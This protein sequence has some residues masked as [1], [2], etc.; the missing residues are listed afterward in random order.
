MKFTNPI[1]PGFAPDPS[2]VRDWE[3]TGHAICRSSQLDLSR[4]FTKLIPLPDER[5]I[6]V[7]GGLFAATIRYHKGFFYVICTN[8]FADP[9]DNTHKFQ[10]FYVTCAEERISSTTGWSDP[11]Y[12][13]FPGIDPSLFIDQDTNRAYVH[14][15]YRSGPPW[16]PDCSI[17]QFEIDLATG[18]PLTDIKFL[19]KGA[20]TDAEGPH[21]YK[22]DGWYYLITA[23]GS[24]FDGHEINIARSRDI[25][26]PYDGYTHNPLLTAKGRDTDIKWTGHGDFVQ[27]EAG[28]WF[29]VHLGI[30]HNKSDPNRHPL[31]RE[32]FLTP[33][34][35]EEGEWPEIA[36]TQLE[37]HAEI[38]DQL[39]HD[40]LVVGNDSAHNTEDVYIRTPEL[41]KYIYDAEK[42]SY[43]IQASSSGLSA[44]LGT[45]SF[46][47]RRQRQQAS[48]AS[49]TLSLSQFDH[50]NSEINA[51]LSVYKDDL[52]YASI[53]FKSKSRELLLEVR[54]VR[55]MK[56]KNRILR[57]KNVPMDFYTIRLRITA[58]LDGYLFE[59]N[60]GELWEPMGRVDSLEMSGYDMT[61]TIFGI[62]ASSSQENGKDDT[63]GEWVKFET[64]IVT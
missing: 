22:K 37:F 48:Q 42:Q 52:R 1:I 60:F 46:V 6:H 21:I 25:W 23:E 35:W 29:C 50:T 18:K 51:G 31:G 28:N 53:A 39:P 19:W 62:C 54:S 3:L 47:G 16:A 13:D 61:G 59:S 9:N 11:C 2:V 32:T 17:R 30:R 27:D 36:Q 40:L 45:T 43:S 12:F 14:G 34:Q 24:T 57:A 10:N 55:D 58:D 7:T 64:F 49:T 38:P 15:S 33:M 26:G 44:P 8:T 63:S 20:S 4:A 41:G 56:V 5:S